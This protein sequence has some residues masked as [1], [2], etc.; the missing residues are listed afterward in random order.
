MTKSAVLGILLA[1]P[2]IANAGDYDGYHQ[3]HDYG[4]GSIAILVGAD[5]QFNGTPWGARGTI[6]LSGDVAQGKDA[7]LAFVLPG[8]W[9][10]TGHNQFGLG[11]TNVIEAPPSLR[12]RMLPQLPVRPYLD[13]G[14]GAVFVTTDDRRDSQLFR[15]RTQDT[16]W[17]TRAV[18]GLEIGANHGPTFILEPVQWQTYHLGRSY[19]R[20]GAQVGLG[21][22]F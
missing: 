21:A 1:A 6:Q 11:H 19:S 15:T 18:F 20:W 16:G 5:S 7:A 12:L 3:Y 4:G 13:A 2:A 10:S 8:T 22:R 9:L 17:M 14:I